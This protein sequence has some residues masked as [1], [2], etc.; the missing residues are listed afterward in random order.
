MNKT[1]EYEIK[2]KSLKPGEEPICKKIIIDVRGNDEILTPESS[3]RIETI[4]AQMMISHL[5]EVVGEL[6]AK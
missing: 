6:V 3:H 4:R 1:A 2:I 5:Y